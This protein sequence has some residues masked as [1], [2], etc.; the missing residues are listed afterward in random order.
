MS[1]VCPL[2]RLLW[3]IGRTVGGWPLSCGVPGRSMAELTAGLC[4]HPALAVCKT[5]VT[6][7]HS[8]VALLP[9]HALG[10]PAGSPAVAHRSNGRGVAPLLWGAGSVHG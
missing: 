7:G 3:R 10:V 1:W 9:V 5:A 8:A 6:F 2:A 4:T